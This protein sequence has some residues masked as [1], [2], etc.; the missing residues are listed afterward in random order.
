MSICKQ[1]SKDSLTY[2]LIYIIQ[3]NLNDSNTDGSIN[4]AVLNSF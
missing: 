1:I 2:R 3:W 4:M